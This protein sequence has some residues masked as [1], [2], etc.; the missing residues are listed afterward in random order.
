[1]RLSSTEIIQHRWQTEQINTERRQNNT[2]RQNIKWSRYRA[3]VAQGVNRG[4]PLLFHDRAT[5]SGWVVSSTPR[6][7]FT[8]EKSRYPLYSRLGGPQDRSGRAENL[9][10]TGIRSRTVQP[11]VSRYTDWTTRPTILTGEN[12]N[13]ESINYPSGTMPTTNPTWISCVLFII[14]FIYCL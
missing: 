13:I 12:W 3:G 6:P 9:V 11:V 7:H 5:R 4:I 10:L 1:M 14:L 8:P 2:D